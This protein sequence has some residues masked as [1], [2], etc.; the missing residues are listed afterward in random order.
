MDDEK[1]KCY[2]DRNVWLRGLFMLL[3]AFLMGVA[4]FVTMVVM[5]LQFLLVLFK[6]QANE[7]LLQFGKSLSV[8][9]YQI[10]LFLTYNSETQPFPMSNWPERNEEIS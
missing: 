4:K 1:V 9:Q 6:G 3:F 8:Y 10:M 5:V 2:K 7:N